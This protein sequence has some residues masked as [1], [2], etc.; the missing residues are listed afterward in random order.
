MKCAIVANGAMSDHT[1]LA[2]R[3][4]SYDLII[5]CDGGARHVAAAGLRPHVLL[6]DFDSIPAELFSQTAPDS[7]V[8]PFPPAKDYTDS[9][10]AIDTALTRGAKHIDLFAVTGSRLDHTLSNVFLLLYIKERGAAGRIVNESNCLFLADEG[11]TLIDGDPGQLLSLIALSDP[12]T[13]VT[14]SGLQYP[15]R[16][17]VLRPSQSIGVSNVFTERQASVSKTNG[18]LLIIL[19]E[20]E[21]IYFKSDEK[22]SSHER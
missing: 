20:D 2:S 8:V 14:L 3:L 18:E 4:L 7:E 11:T 16:D 13:G 10:L 22:R 17:A 15:L 19:A 6:G 12:V 21:S 9:H 5:A 1:G